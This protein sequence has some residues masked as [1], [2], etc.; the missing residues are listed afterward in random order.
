MPS[1]LFSFTEETAVLPVSPNALRS[2]IQVLPAIIK[3][4]LHLYQE[5]GV[6]NLHKTREI[7]HSVLK[8]D[9]FRLNRVVPEGYPLPDNFLCRCLKLDGY[10]LYVFVLEVLDEVKLAPAILVQ[11]QD[12]K[13][14]VGLLVD[15]VEHPYQK[16]DKSIE[17]DVQLLGLSNIREA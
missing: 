1:L 11:L 7:F 13:E 16:A 4:L 12:G 6:L 10:E 2:R 3:R 14:H 15:V 5:A 17:I 9:Q 8:E